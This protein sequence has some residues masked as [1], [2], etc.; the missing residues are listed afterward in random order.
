MYNN[1]ACYRKRTLG[2]SLL[3]VKG[4]MEIFHT[5]IHCGMVR[6]VGVIVLAAPSTIHHG[7]ANNSHSQ[8]QTILS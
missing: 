7:S 4:E 3:V 6:D 1:A 2:F 8:L 5:E